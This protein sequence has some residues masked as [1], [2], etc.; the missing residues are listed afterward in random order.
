M[1]KEKTELVGFA[2]TQI[3]QGH[4]SATTALSATNKHRR[5]AVSGTQDG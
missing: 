3:G 4:S 1:L 5:R 2:M